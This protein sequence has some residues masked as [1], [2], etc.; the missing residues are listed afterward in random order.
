MERS[1]IT[2]GWL[3]VP[4][5][6]SAA[7][8]SDS[9]KLDDERSQEGHSLALFANQEDRHLKK[10]QDVLKAL[11]ETPD[12]PYT[13]FLY[14]QQS[15]EL[16]KDSFKSM[17]EG[18][19]PSLPD[20]F[21]ITSGTQNKRTSVLFR[22]A[23]V[24]NREVMDNIS[25]Y[26]KSIFPELSMASPETSGAELIEQT[27]MA[28]L[29]ILGGVALQN[30]R[31]GGYSV[32]PDEENCFDRHNCDEGFY[33]ARALWKMQTECF[34]LAMPLISA[35]SSA[36]RR[37]QAREGVPTGTSREQI[38]YGNV[39]KP[40]QQDAAKSV[41]GKLYYTVHSSLPVCRDR[42]AANRVRDT[43]GKRILNYLLMSIASLEGCH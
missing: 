37:A 22:W 34:K 11:Y 18:I 3:L 14:D 15:F 43:T 27:G 20:Y 25:T 33:Q 26:L 12:S 30:V 13:V 2:Q 36:L 32:E 6:I 5:L 7:C 9:G 35:A 17:L 41:G 19:D 8:A 23:Q 38:S 42:I 16:L 21:T 24:P 29:D 28:R 40:T 1:K 10:A 31:G 4:V 39:T